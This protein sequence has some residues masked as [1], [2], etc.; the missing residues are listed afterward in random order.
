LLPLY[1]QTLA[2][3]PTKHPQA[4]S[5]K[6]AEGTQSKATGQVTIT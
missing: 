1:L 5:V 6:A 4:M 3:S 2:A